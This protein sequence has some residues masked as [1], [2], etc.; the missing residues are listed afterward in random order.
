MITAV[1]TNV[2]IDVLT[3]DERY[4]AGSARALSACV[5][6]GSVVAS[7]VVWA[8]TAAG[9]SDL[10]AFRDTM[11]RLGVTFAPV[12]QAAAEAASTA[13]KLYRAQ[14]GTRSRILGD[15]LVGAHARHQADRLLTRDRGFIR[16]YFVELT[17]VDPSAGGPAGT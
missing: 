10:G 7:E 16:R 1:D 2:L 12:Q 4:A 6:D 3:G 15:F 9:Y 5:R 17:V 14:G 11:T 8:E 13:W